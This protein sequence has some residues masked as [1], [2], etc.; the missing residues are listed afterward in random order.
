[1][2]IRI[3][4]LIY[5]ILVHLGMILIMIRVY[6]H[7]RTAFFLIEFLVIVSMAA[8]VTLFNKLWKPF[9][10][11]KNAAGWLRESDYTNRYNETGDRDLDRLIDVYNQMLQQLNE[12]TLRQGEQR[13]LMEKLLEATPLA[14][15]TL[16]FDHRIALLNPAMARLIGPEQELKGLALEEVD[17]PLTQLMLDL[18]VGQ[19]QVV[20]YAGRRR[21]KCILDA[22]RDRGFSRRYYIVEDITEELHRSEKAAYG[23][24]IRVLS[25]EVNNTVGSANSLL[26]TI[27]DYGDELALDQREDF[28]TA[29]NVV[30]NRMDNLN[31]F[32]RAYA[33]V[34]RIPEP[35]LLPIDLV[36]MIEGVH[37][38]FS[39]ELAERRIEWRPTLPPQPTLIP[40]DQH[41]IEQALVNI[42]RNGIQ[43]IGRDG[44]LR[45]ELTQESVGYVLRI[46][47][48]GRKLTPEIKQKL[49]TPFYT[50]KQDGQGIGLTLIKDILLS[51]GFDFSLQG[52]AHQDTCFTIK[53]TR[54]GLVSKP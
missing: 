9:D 43:A 44:V 38:L 16:D 47:D 30:I 35:K 17:H 45:V 13:G 15:M 49:F 23:K 2:T 12:E 33:N 1:M 37:I 7:D 32:M 24:L 5:L 39:A 4:L 54:S 52:D 27:L 48:P 31:R 3:R 8:G 50:S 40:L 29:L 18:E 21:L 34:V 20:S 22:F 11:L 14:V 6:P 10:F 25:H 51:H 41:Q 42:V 19:Q 36:K 46:F 53:L 26:H 28:S